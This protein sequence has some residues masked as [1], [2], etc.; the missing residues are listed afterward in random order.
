[1]S[2]QE[3]HCTMDRRRFLKLSGILGIGFATGGLLPISES[4]A[5]NRKL[6]KVTKTRQGMGTFVSITVMH[7]SKAEAEEAI[8]GAFEKIG[9]LTSLLDRYRSDSPVGILNKEG[10]L[11]DMPP[12]MARVVARSLYFH[13]LSHGAFD[14]TVQPLVDLCKHHFEA[15]KRPPSEGDL[16]KVLRLVDASAVTFNGRL[17]RFEKEGM[18]ITLDGIAKGYIID[19]AAE[20]IKHRGIEHILINAGGDIRAAG[21]K[22]NGMPWKVGIQNPDK[23]G[24]Y[25]DIVKMNNGAIATSGNYEIYFDEEKLYHHIVNPRTGLSPRQSDSVTVMASNVMDADALSTAVF[26]LEPDAGRRFIEGI[27]GSACL[28]LGR[29]KRRIA[30]RGWPC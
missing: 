24:P 17:I 4:V 14:I 20:F 5:F 19:Q 7:S 28:I 8:G 2:A 6:Y 13:K 23:A 16:D 26:V 21:G 15:Y 22:K 1:M 25:L 10:Q 12:D 3:K 29:D 18:G 11:G 9:C 30:S 27:A